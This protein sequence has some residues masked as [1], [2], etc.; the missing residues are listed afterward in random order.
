MPS[1][2]SVTK[3]YFLEEGAKLVLNTLDHLM[4]R[5]DVFLPIVV[6]IMLSNRMEHAEDVKQI[7]V[8]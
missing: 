1:T 4:I 7:H 2:V 5:R 8:S 6:I 3:N